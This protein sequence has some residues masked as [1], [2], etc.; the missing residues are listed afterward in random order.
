MF[1]NPDRNLIAPDHGLGLSVTGVTVNA[2]TP[3]RPKWPR[4]HSHPKGRV[5]PAGA[6]SARCPQCL[7]AIRDRIAVSAGYCARCQDFTLMCAAGR[8][9][10]S[11]DVMT[12]TGWH[13]PCTSAGMTKWRVTDQNGMTTVLLCA[14]HGMELA[15]GRVSWIVQPVFIGT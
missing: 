13:W 2:A 12:R 8:R 6:P 5:S 15:S 3:A 11:P 4:R 1:S 14:A 10:V 7:S 9:L